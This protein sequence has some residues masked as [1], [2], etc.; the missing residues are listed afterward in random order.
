MPLPLTMSFF[1][2]K[3][4]LLVLNMLVW[5]DEAE[6]IIALGEVICDISVLITGEAME[7]D[8]NGLPTV[9]LSPGSTCGEE[10]CVQ[11]VVHKE[12]KHTIVATDRTQ[13]YTISGALLFREIGNVDER[14]LETLRLKTLELYQRKQTYRTEF[15]DWSSRATLDSAPM[16][17]LRP[18]GNR[19]GSF[20]GGSFE[21]PALPSFNGDYTM[22]ST[23]KKVKRIL[24][25]DKTVRIVDE[26]GE[27]ETYAPRGTHD[28]HLQEQIDRIIDQQTLQSRKLDLLMEKFDL[29]VSRQSSESPDADLPPSAS[30]NVEKA[31]DDRTKLAGPLDD[32]PGEEEKKPPHSSAGPLSFGTDPTA[33]PPPL[34]SASAIRGIVHPAAE[35]E[36]ETRDTEA[37]SREPGSWH[38]KPGHRL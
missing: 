4:P 26:A 11:A 18:M 34:P 27:Q 21:S 2:L 16:L 5:F 10:A 8:V 9:W 19:D 30:M 32:L 6:V 15:G 35:V 31:T 20:G 12:A 24:S 13:L 1:L 28:D 36:T 7:I 38:L 33:P 25:S 3:C 14:I 29:V 23:G 17:P 22:A 37:S